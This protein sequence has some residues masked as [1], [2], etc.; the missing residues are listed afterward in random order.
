MK[1]A[2]M[3]SKCINILCFLC[4]LAVPLIA[5]PGS[6]IEQHRSCTRCG[7]D[8]KAY[9][10][11]RMLIQYEDGTEIGICSLHC[12]VQELDSR[13]DKLAK[14]I[15]VADR[16]THML[17]DAKQAV[18]VI[19]GSKRGVMTQVPKWVFETRA[20]AEKFVKT[21]GGKIVSWDDALAAAQEE[22]AKNQ[23]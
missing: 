9:G 13:P 18:W 8:R 7:M 5:L 16:S 19:G 2:T 22:Q 3:I 15:Y 4:V 17:I 21:Y 23:R 10:Y 6:D 20:G 12:A 14:N 1:G 11:S